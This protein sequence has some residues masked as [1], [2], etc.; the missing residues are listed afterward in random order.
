MRTGGCQCGEV[1]FSLKGEAGALYVC[2]CRE[3]RKQSASAFGLSLDVPRSSLTLTAGEPG[4]WSRG[5][6]SGRRLDCF[7]CPTCGTRLWHVG[8]GSPDR[9]TVK[10]GALDDD[11]DISRATHI[12]TKRRLEGVIIPEGCE[13]FAEEPPAG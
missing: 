4:S 8:G 10:G 3:C 2:H 13:S 6:D 7:F 1:R 11:V 9:V 12:W 5:T